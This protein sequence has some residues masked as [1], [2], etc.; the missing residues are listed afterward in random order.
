MVEWLGCRESEVRGVVSEK[1]SKKATHGSSGRHES[2]DQGGGSDATYFLIAG[3][4]HNAGMDAGMNEP[5]P[6]V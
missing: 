2:Q 3:W 1:T 5:Y 4:M 6:H